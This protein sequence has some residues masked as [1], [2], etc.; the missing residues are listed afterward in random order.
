MD[1]TSTR[2]YLNTLSS[3]SD[4]RAGSYALSALRKMTGTDNFL[5]Q[6]EADRKCRIASLEDCQARSFLETVQERCGCVPWA[7]AAALQSQVLLYST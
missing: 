7:S 6:T 4:S 1:A 5:K 2:L 3:F